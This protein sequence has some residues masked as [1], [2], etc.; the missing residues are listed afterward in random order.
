MQGLKSSSNMNL[1]NIL[2]VNDHNNTKSIPIPKYKSHINYLAMETVLFEKLHNIKLSQS[3][4]ESPRSSSDS[5]K[6]ALSI[7][8]QYAHDFDENLKT[9]CSKLV[10]NNVFD[11]ESH[12]ERQCILSYFAFIK[13]CSDNPA[14]CKFQIT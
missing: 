4:L 12:N 8:L 5:T 3:I 7:L 9:L 6:A 2:N 11:H 1:S 14:D 13:L 10:T